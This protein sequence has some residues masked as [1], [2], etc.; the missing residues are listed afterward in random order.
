M[1]GMQGDGL[2]GG[3]TTLT[4]TALERMQATQRG[5]ARDRLPCQ[6]LFM[7]FGARLSGVRYRD[8]VLDHRKLVESYLRVLDEFE[9][10]AVSCCSDAWREAHDCGARVIF[11]DDAPPACKDHL[12]ADKATFAGLRMPSPETGPRMAT[13]SSS[14]GAVLGR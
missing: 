4:M 11:F 5:E 13:R 2:P 8:Y 7:T 12:L 1:Y 3:N 9:I 6:P 10:D 14:K